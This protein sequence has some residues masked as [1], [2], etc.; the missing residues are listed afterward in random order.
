MSANKCNVFVTETQTQFKVAD[1]IFIMKRTK[2]SFGCMFVK[3][4]FSI[5]RESHLVTADHAEI[6][7]TYFDL[8][9]YRKLKNVL[10]TL[11]PFGKEQQL[12]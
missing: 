9:A 6:L 2:S 10:D 3:E 8:I 1:D 12:A 7:M 4:D 11:R 5:K